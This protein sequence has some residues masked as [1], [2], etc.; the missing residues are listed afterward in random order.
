MRFPHFLILRTSFLNFK[1]VIVSLICGVTV[2][3]CASE[4]PLVLDTPAHLE[5]IQKD[6]S[7][8]YAPTGLRGD[9][10]F[11]LSIEEAMRR[12]KKYNL[13][14]RVAA[15]E[16]LIAKDNISLAQ[17]EGAPNITGSGTFTRRNNLSA[18][19]SESIST[20]T[21]SLESSTSSEK[22]RRLADLQGQW[23]ILDSVIAYLEGK[24]AGDR[25]VTAKERL[26]KVLQNIERDV[27]SAYWQALIG[28]RFEKG[29]Q[30]SLNQLKRK[31]RD[32]Q[33]AVKSKDLSIGDASNQLDKVVSQRSQISV[34]NEAVALTNSELK[35]IA[36]IPMEREVDLT[37]ALLPI[38]P[39]FEGMGDK[40]RINN[41]IQIALKNRPELREE[42][43][44]KNIAVRDKE[45]ELIKTFPGLNIIYSRN[46]DSNKFLRRD[47]WSN[48]ST[49]VTQSITDFISLPTR[50]RAAENRELLT[51]ERRKALTAAIIAQVHIAQ[52]RIDV[53]KETYD[54][55]KSRNEIAQQKLKLVSEK[56]KLGAASGL[57]FV[58]NNTDGILSDIAQQQALA[59]LNQSYVDMMQTI[60]LSLSQAQ[61]AML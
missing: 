33:K 60:G 2:V 57:E 24:S 32:L 54:L 14:A 25:E 46:Y 36:S 9:E 35:A 20:G 11:R 38:S 39:K 50:Y 45:R 55:A 6:K 58:Q 15:L 3:G 21:Q 49:A 19:S 51:N 29:I 53:A 22:A 34:I 48:F 59:D 37:G 26:R 40:S 27:Y 41:F 13:D 31:E 56:N 28:Q 10:V 17:F 16:A 1:G 43:M 5:Q 30:K 8:A 61:E 52:I 42:F 7:K 23:N 12:A 47:S 4:T 44:N 18:S